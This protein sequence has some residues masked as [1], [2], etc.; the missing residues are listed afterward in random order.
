MRRYRFL[1]H[2]L[3]RFEGRTGFAATLLA[4]GLLT[5]VMAPSPEPPG[6]RAHRT[7]AGHDRL[8]VAGRERDR[9]AACVAPGGHP[10][11]TPDRACDR[12]GADRTLPR[13]N[14]RVAPGKD[15]PGA[16]RRPGWR[17]RPL[18]TASR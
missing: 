15:G 14:G 12:A 2:S 17:A 11:G 13:G 3:R 8:R 6:P 1:P 4:A 9:I 16:V 7:V 5:G 18:A 10:P